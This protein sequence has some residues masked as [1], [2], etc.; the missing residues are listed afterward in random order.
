MIKNTITKN[1]NIY[2]EDRLLNTFKELTNRYT[3]ASDSELKGYGRFYLHFTSELIPELPTDG[4]LR[5]FKVSENSI[6]LMGKSD[7]FYNAKIYDFTGRLI[8]E[9]SFNHKTDVDSLTKGVH[10]LHIIENSSLTVKK[11][12]VD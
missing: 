11:F 9:L 3:I 8:K 12:V 1:T 5:V 10:I 4:N 2:L 7:K 6:R